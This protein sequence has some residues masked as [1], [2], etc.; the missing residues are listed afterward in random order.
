MLT[1]VVEIDASIGLDSISEDLMA[2]LDALEP[3]GNKNAQPVFCA[4][5]VS[6]LAKR[7]VGHDAA[8][9]KMTLERDGRPFDAIAFRMGD[10]AQGLPE[11]VDIAFHI[12]RNNY[13]GYETLQLRVVDI[14]SA[15][16][17][18]DEILTEWID[19]I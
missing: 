10:L 16:T 8:H 12:E 4:E 15:N 13:L 17:L 19:A 1:P 11:I 2:F 9:L 5:G 6:V 14:R 3:F 7:T 18:E